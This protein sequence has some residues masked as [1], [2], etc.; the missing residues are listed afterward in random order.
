MYPL[1]LDLTGVRD[2][3]EALKRV[4]EQRRKVPNRGLGYGLLRYPPAEDEIVRRL[5]AL[6]QAEVRFNYLGQLDH[7]VSG[8]SPLE[9][10]AGAA[11]RLL[12]PLARRRYLV[13]VHGSVGAGRMRFDLGYSESVHRRATVERLA[14]ALLKEVRALIAHCLS[15]EASGYTPSD[16][17]DIGLGQNE[18]DDLLAQ[19]E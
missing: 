4:K 8:S 2:A 18:L 5:A 17:P 9:P 10:S 15:P 11:G 13:D 16:F 19:L 1:G 6:P 7:V 3:G 14:A 12:S